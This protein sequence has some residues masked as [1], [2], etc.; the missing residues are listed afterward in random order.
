M[1][2]PF[3]ALAIVLLLALSSVLFEERIPLNR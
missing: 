1:A 2:Y 3:M